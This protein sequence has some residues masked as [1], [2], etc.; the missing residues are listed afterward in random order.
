MPVSPAFPPA[1]AAPA[2]P[3]APP[4]PL[5]GAAAL[6]P[7]PRFGFACPLLR[8]S[9]PEVVQAPPKNT[10]HTTSTSVRTMAPSRGVKD[11]GCIK[12]GGS[13]KEYEQHLTRAVS[14]S[15]VACR[16]KNS[17]GAPESPKRA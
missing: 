17:Q 4:A 7:R 2:E 14:A 8:S 12:V 13:P 15:L 11:R 5:S 16:D 6:P 1:P 3:A 9:N 10:A